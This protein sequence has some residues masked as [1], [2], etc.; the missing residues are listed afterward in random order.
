MAT[1]LA[2]TFHCYLEQT[3]HESTVLEIK[4]SPGV[5]TATPRD[6]GA[7]R[8]K[9]SKGLRVVCY[10]LLWSAMVCY[11]LLTAQVA[12]GHVMEFLCRVPRGSPKISIARNPSPS[13][14]LRFIPY[15]GGL[16]LT[17]KLIQTHIRT[18]RYVQV[19]FTHP[20]PWSWMK[21]VWLNQW[22]PTII[23]YPIQLFI[24]FHHISNTSSEFVRFHFQHLSP[25]DG[26]G[27]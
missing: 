1:I 8:P 3:D 23:N 10:G 4:T 26:D 22:N 16:S 17:S 12:D 11:G 14:H 27:G 2:L 15:S 25:A 18:W 6:A 20:Q 13:S 24:L 5:T 21:Y 9:K 7:R 19:N